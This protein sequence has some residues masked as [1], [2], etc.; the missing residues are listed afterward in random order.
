MCQCFLKYWIIQKK[1]QRFYDQFFL[2]HNSVRIT[3]NIELCRNN[4]IYIETTNKIS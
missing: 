3:R 2:D 1:K 4:K